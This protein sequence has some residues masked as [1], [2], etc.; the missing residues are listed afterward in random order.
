[1]SQ[2]D[3]PTL[4]GLNG[5]GG[6]DEVEARLFHLAIGS[7]VDPAGTLVR[8]HLATGGKRM[9]AKLAL[10]AAEAFHLD[11][12][13]VVGWAAA[14]E[15]VHNATLVHDDIEDGDIVR[16][17]RPTLWATC[18]M[19]QA[20]NAGDLMLMLPFIA[21]ESLDC[22]D[23]LRWKLAN[24]IARHAERTARSQ[25]LELDLLENRRFDAASWNEAAEGKS[26]PLLALPVE[27]AAILARVAPA[28]AKRI[29]AAFSRIG[30]LYQLH[31]DVLDCF[32]DKGRGQL[33]N[34]LREGKVSALIVEHLRLH[35]D[36]HDQ[37]VALLETPRNETSEDEV[38]AMI[39]RFRDGGAL[40]AVEARI[41]ALEAEI[42]NWPLLAAVPDVHALAVTLVHAIRRAR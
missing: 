36:E 7:R 32:G 38:L 10:A 12:R 19:A 30:A 6:L 42:L 35:P 16:R 22:D 26:G 23:G 11:R 14:C 2:V 31:D 3:H 18:G 20:I 27:G 21:L 33:G 39:A 28:S 24:A 4:E 37:V 9:R 5:R 15:M 1:M 41:V 29:A 40:A 13:A 8:D 34:D 17:G 25:A